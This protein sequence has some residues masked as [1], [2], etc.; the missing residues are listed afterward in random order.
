VSTIV[1]TGAAGALGRRV[2]A[3]LADDPDVDRVLALDRV[4]PP[5][6]PRPGVEHRRVDLATDDVKQL[7]H[8]ADVVIHLASVFG[9]ALDDHPAVTS[10]TEVRIARRLLDAAADV[11]VPT[12]VLLSTAAVYGAW[13]NNPVPL[14]ED[15]PLRPNP[16]CA[17]AVQR[18]EI[19][20]LAGEW[21]LEQPGSRLVVLRA[22]PVVAD[23]YQSWLAKALAAA[24]A[25]VGADEP[26]AQYVHV[27][28][29]AAAV[30]RVRRSDVR[31]PVNV[32]PEGWLSGEEVKAL[33]TG[34]P[35]L[36][37]PARFAGRVARFRWR[38][39]L[40]PT[41]PG[42]VP[43]RWQPWVVA[44]DKLRATGWEPEH[45]NDEA[46]V[47]GHDAGPLAT[48]SP[49][50]RQELA[51]G[52]AGGVLAGVAAGAALLIRRRHRTRS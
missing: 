43:Y 39:R 50:R 52:V 21:A 42:V 38:F 51:L 8:E 28:D 14:T 16:D 5:A 25:P 33:A 44:T 12:F 40:A 1:V 2:V 22:A 3:L 45:T 46:F 30:D 49:R 26:P 13:P 19:E 27:D 36:R 7:L 41:P 23:G 37:S 6:P 47:S 29:V 15:A 32:A 9:P 48:L 31:G 20:R 4:E 24:P 18:A 11:A 17:Y 34:S 10:G 35:T